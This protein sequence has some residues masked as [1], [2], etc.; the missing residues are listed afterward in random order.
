MKKLEEKCKSA[1]HVVTKVLRITSGSLE[2]LLERF[3][4]L[5]VLH[6]YRDPRAVVNSRMKWTNYPVGNVF[7]NARILCDKMLVDLLGGIKMVERFKNR[8]KFIFYEDILLET[9][10]KVTVLFDFLG[11]QHITAN[12]KTNIRNDQ[13]STSS[14][15]PEELFVRKANNA[16]WWQY[17]LSYDMVNLIHSQCRDITVI[18]NMTHFANAILLQNMSTPSI[19][20]PDFFKLIQL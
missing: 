19:V 8:F 10:E 5:K 14:E 15:C 20:L 6:L 12:T 9:T 1:D 18:F 4:N 7:Q 17:S 2:T 16:F 11:M 3:D 13:C